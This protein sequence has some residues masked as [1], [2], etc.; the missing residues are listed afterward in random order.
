[1][2]RD[3][4]DA[5]LRAGLAQETEAQEARI[6]AEVALAQGHP[7]AAVDA[8]AV[9]RERAAAPRRLATHRGARARDAAKQAA[10]RAAAVALIVLAIVLIVAVVGA[11][12]YPCRMRSR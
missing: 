6:E 4:S 2:L 7:N 8:E 12:L 9:R 10:E 3:S 1:M 11:G 5:Q